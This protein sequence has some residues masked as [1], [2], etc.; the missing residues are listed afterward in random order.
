MKFK[1]IYIVAGLIGLFFLL[2]SRAG[3]PATQQNLRVTGAPTEGT[4]ANTGCHTGSAFNPTLS[5]SLFDNGN[6]TI[7]YDPGKTYTLK[8]TNSPISGTPSVYGFQ[9]VSLSASNV[10]AGSW[11]TSP[12][13]MT[14]K[15]LGG[16]NY[17]EHSEP[18]TNGVFEL[19]WVAPA[20]GTGAVTFYAASLAGNGNDQS[21]GDG[22]TKNTLVIQENGTS[23][24]GELAQDVAS[25]EV[26]PNPVSDVM[27]LR[28]TSRLAGPH[29]IHVFSANGAML[30]TEP[31]NVQV[32]QTTTSVPVD[33]L[34]PGL[35]LV[36][37]CG[38]G[39][40]AAVQMLKK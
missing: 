38:E 33:E 4:C 30:K 20:A 40:M 39:H 1:N 24:T 6:L 32:G 10:Q 22:M 26:M 21:S 8:I 7:K 2:Q 5:M 11:G 19:P 16:R 31:V 27:N 9:A 28:I 18:A 29:K 3:G 13:G 34:T 23:S 17:I 12:A 14:Q 25:L 15:T 35:Y 37:L 36:Q